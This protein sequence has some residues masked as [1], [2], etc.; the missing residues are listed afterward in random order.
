[1]TTLSFYQ[2]GWELSVGVKGEK[3]R[4]ILLALLQAKQGAGGPLHF[5]ETICKKKD[6]GEASLSRTQD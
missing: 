6:C 2:R 1:M 5:L 3:T 4:A